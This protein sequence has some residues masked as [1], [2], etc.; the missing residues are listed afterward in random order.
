VAAPVSLVV[1]YGIRDADATGLGETF[2]TRS[3]VHSVAINLR[4][5]DS[6]RFLYWRLTTWRRSPHISLGCRFIGFL[7]TVGEM[8]E[9]YQLP[10]CRE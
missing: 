9:V 5:L 3:D 2:Q 10:F 8:K 4:A 6:L 7:K 1:V